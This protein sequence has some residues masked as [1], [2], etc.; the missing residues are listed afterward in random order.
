MV[1]IN[2]KVTNMRMTPDVEEYVN[3][4]LAK[5]EH[6]TENLQEEVIL[7]VE[8][9]KTTAHH[10][11]GQIYRAEIQARVLGKDL[12]AVSER[13]DLLSAIDEAKDEFIREITHW[14]GKEAALFKRGARRIKALLQRWYGES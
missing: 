6:L 4:K 1:K 9:G 12:R 7:R 2:L 14:K 3:K 11:H 5:I 13:E 8:V 10:E